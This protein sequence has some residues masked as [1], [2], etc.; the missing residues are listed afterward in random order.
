LTIRDLAAVEA[1][2]T[3]SA[4]AFFAVGLAALAIARLVGV[5]E[6]SRARDGRPP[7][8]NRQW[9]AVMLGTVGTLLL[10]VLA[11]DAI[12]SFDLIAAAARPFLNVLGTVLYWV[13]YAIALQIG[14]L[15]E[16]LIQ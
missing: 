13:I 9:L 4:I 5:R 14:L 8:V 16:L 15:V 10:A 12:L 2:A 11:L 1:E 6:R 7:A 3:P